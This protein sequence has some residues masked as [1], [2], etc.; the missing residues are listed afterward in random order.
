MAGLRNLWTRAMLRGSSFTNSF[1]RLKL[2]YSIEDPWG[3]ASTREQ[4]RF[5]TTTAML[6]NMKP[7]FD[8]ILELG[9]GE[10]HQSLHLAAIADDLQGVELSPQA[11]DRARV[12][13]PEATFHAGEVADV[14][15]LLGDR[16]FDLI[17]ACEV[18]YYISEGKAAVAMLQERTDRLF[19]SNYK[20]RADQMT[21]LFEGPGW[22][23]LDDITAE[24]TVWECRIWERPQTG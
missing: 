17:V 15:R 14:P 1:R 9:S 4:S 20:P 16:R 24:G 18:L 21:G 22:R 2:L 6:E 12:R 10:G 7:R 11:V 23:R 13:C 3:M 19:V 5:A 8:D